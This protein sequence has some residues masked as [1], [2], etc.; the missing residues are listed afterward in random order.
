MRRIYM[1]TDYL[2]WIN[3]R[4]VPR[5]SGC[6]AMRATRTFYRGFCIHTFGKD[7]SWSFSASPL[8]PDLPILSRYAFASLG[9]T[10]T[11]ALTEARARID[12]VLEPGGELKIATSTKPLDM[13]CR[14]ARASIWKDKRGL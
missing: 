2:E 14:V 5:L 4:C 8:T 6:K 7:S 10:E 12:R 3:F 1:K 13:S 9:E 11:M